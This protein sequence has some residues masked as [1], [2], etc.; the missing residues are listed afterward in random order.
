LT[1]GA[2]EAT[3]HSL[4]SPSGMARLFL[5]GENGH[6]PDLPETWERLV[7]NPGGVYAREALTLPIQLLNPAT[8]DRQVLRMTLLP[9]LLDVAA[10][11]LKQADE[12]VAFFELDRTFFRRRHGLPY[13]RRTLG[14]ALTGKRRPQNWEEPQP[15]P[16]S[17]YDVKGMVEAALDALQ[18]EGWEVEATPHPALHP[19]RSAALRVQGREVGYLGQLHPEVASRFEIDGWPVQVAELDLDTLFEVASDLHAFRPIPRYP[20]AHRD[21]AVVVDRAV[22]SGAIIRIIRAAAGPLLE[23]ARIFDVYI[24]APLTEGAK[25]VAVGL[26]LRAPGAT[27]TQEEI[28]AVM[29]RVVQALGAE[30]NASLRE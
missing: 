12:R 19:G 15:R 11:N 21:L 2:N 29:Q 8:V 10:H 25:S 27:L 26:A 30:L 18:V 5:P 6:Q 20:A 7:A 1:C 24:G 4:T 28:S 9:S 16:Y 13:E 3:T 22:L 14:V 17:F 23:S